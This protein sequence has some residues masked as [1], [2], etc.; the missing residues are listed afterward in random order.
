MFKGLALE[1][2]GQNYGQKVIAAARNRATHSRTDSGNCAPSGRNSRRV[3][4]SNLKLD[5]QLRIACSVRRRGTT[6]WWIAARTLD[7]VSCDRTCLRF[8][9]QNFAHIITC[10]VRERNELHGF[11]GEPIGLDEAATT[12]TVVKQGAERTL[13]CDDQRGRNQEKPGEHR[14]DRLL[15]YSMAS[16]FAHSIPMLF[17]VGVGDS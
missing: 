11:V 1:K 14:R 13:Q 6:L 10:N 8:G 9:K 7:Y 5:V 16:S 15:K 12:G 3:P 17:E 4:T 2:D